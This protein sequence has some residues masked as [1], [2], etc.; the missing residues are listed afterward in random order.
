MKCDYKRVEDLKQIYNYIRRVGE[1]IPYFFDA[2]YE[3]WEESFIG[4]TD[5]D[6]EEMFAELKT[7]AAY[8]EETIVGFIQFGIPRYIYG[9]NG[10]D[11]RC[12]CGVIRNL[13]FDGESGCGDELLEIAE[14][15]FRD[16]G[17]ANKFA[18]YH[19]LGMTCYAWHGKLFYGQDHVEA[20]LL[21]HGFGIEHENVYFSRMLTENDTN[22]SGNVNL[23]FGKT[24]L[25][26]V[27]GFKI[28]T[29]KETIGAGELVYLPQGG[30]CY[31]KWIFIS[32]QFKRKS[33]A[34]SAMRKLFKTLYKKG[35]RRFDTDTASD[36]EA[37]CGLYNKL[38]F[39]DMGRTR[40]Y[41]L[42]NK[43]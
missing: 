24:N 16:K 42:L 25:K 43:K 12:D 5:C 15:Y 38:G 8:S 23:L 30:I 11:Y 26:G 17:T 22:Y 21:R 4:D 39:T 29:E 1:R 28:Q 27:C 32:E 9:E 3:L 35:I 10:K 36:N 14:K 18:F 13:Y 34:D 20:T 41:L 40:S 6:G 37:A 31:L 2:D 19:A 33:Y 7:Y